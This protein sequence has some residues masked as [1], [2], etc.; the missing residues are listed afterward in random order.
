M[1]LI[2]SFY[3]CK[4]EM[5]SIFSIVLL[6]FICVSAVNTLSFTVNPHPIDS[7]LSILPEAETSDSSEDIEDMVNHNFKDAENEFNRFI[8]TRSLYSTTN[9]LVESDH[10]I[11]L[12]RP[13]RL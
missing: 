4:A 8:T 2:F 6:A 12:R 5:K 11:S 7:E 1:K 3:A 13:P 10:S 9:V